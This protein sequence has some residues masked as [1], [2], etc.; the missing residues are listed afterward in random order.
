MNIGNITGVVRNRMLNQ[1]WYSSRKNVP[2]SMS[3]GAQRIVRKNWDWIF[4]LL[5]HNLRGETRTRRRRRRRT[6]LDEPGGFG[7][8]SKIGRNHET[9]NKTFKV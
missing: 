8:E 5:R 3:V 9:M 2:H 6:A 1:D 7:R 4:F